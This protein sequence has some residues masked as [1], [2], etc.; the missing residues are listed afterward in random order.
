VGSREFRG[1]FRNPSAFATHSF[2]DV[3]Y[4]EWIREVRIGPPVFPDGKDWEKK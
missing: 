3:H 4:L 2:H 1:A